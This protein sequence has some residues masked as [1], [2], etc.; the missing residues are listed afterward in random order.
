MQYILNLY[1][2]LEF[3]QKFKVKFSVYF[4]CFRDPCDTPMVWLRL[5]GILVMVSIDDKVNNLA[6]VTFC[7]NNGIEFG[8]IKTFL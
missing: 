8:S 6:N 7:G 1:I 4:K 3:V 2:P 5:K